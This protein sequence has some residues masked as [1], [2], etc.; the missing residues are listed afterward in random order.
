VLNPGSD[1][2]SGLG[3]ESISNQ[4]FYV[5]SIALFT[6]GFNHLSKYGTGTYLP[7]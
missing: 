7:S 4:N 1:L 5:N 6:F 3:V 2:G